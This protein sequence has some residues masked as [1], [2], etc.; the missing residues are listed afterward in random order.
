[1]GLLGKAKKLIEWNRLGLRLNK[2]KDA[3]E[4]EAMTTQTPATYDPT[5]TA[6]KATFAL[7]EA[8]LWVCVTAIGAFLVDSAA[9]EAVFRKA[10]FPSALVVVLVAALRA[11]GEAANNWIKNRDK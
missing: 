10:G 8:L 6:K 9:V 2:V 7:A 1:M 3:I 11:V 4:R 5:I